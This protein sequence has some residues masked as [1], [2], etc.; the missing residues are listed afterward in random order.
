MKEKS[1]SKGIFLYPQKRF[2]N[3]PIVAITGSDKKQECLQSGMNDFLLK[4]VS[5]NIF[6]DMVKKHL[7]AV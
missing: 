4:P 1:P 3:V 7:I 6:N 2:S 5:K